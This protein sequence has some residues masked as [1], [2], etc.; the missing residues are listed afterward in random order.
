[1]RAIREACRGYEVPRCKS[2]NRHLRCVFCPSPSADSLILDCDKMRVLRGIRGVISDCIVAERHGSLHMAV[3]EF[4]GGSYSPGH[5]RS[6]LMA[7]ARL[8]MDLLAEAKFR[9][10]PQIHLVVVAPRHPA[11]QRKS[12]FRGPVTVCGRKLRIHTVRCGAR[13]SQVI[14]GA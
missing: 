4:K 8:A 10:E 2:K 14:Y 1:M 11:Q 6:Q 7:G 9:A 13:F 12:L 3:V 5:T